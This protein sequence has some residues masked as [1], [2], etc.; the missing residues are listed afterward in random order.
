MKGSI[1][2]IPTF[3]KLSQGPDYFSYQEILKSIESRLVYVHQ[4]TPAKGTS[5]KTQ[6]QC[7]IE[8]KI[9]DYFY[10]TYGN[11]G[12]YLIGQFISP[13]NIFSDK[14]DGWIDRPYRLIF[15][16]KSNNYFKGD[17]KWWTPNDNST[18][19]LVPE[20]ELTLFE[21]LILKPFFD[22]NLKNFG[23]QI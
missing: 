7:F 12:I 22:I 16:S 20:H 15:H 14:G 8:A 23:I 4:E 19:T 13:A 17:Q 11:Y 2:M 3:W 9:G 6:G 10:F 1:K 21:N 18:F 5:S